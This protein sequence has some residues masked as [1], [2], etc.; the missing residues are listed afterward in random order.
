MKWKQKIAIFALAVV[1]VQPKAEVA[2]IPGSEPLRQMFG[3]ASLVCRCSVLSVKILH[4][5]KIPGDLHGNTYN[6]MSALLKEDKVYKADHKGFQNITVIYDEYPFSSGVGL[7]GGEYDR[8]FFLKV[9]GSNYAFVEPRIVF[10]LP[11]APS[12]EGSGIEQLERDLIAGLETSDRS[13]LLNTLRLLQA[14]DKLS[15]NSLAVLK[16]LLPASD[17]EM[18]LAIHAVLI[19]TGDPEEVAKFAAFEEKNRSEAF[20]RHLSFTSSMRIISIASALNQVRNVEALPSLIQLAESPITSIRLCALEA[21]R[22]IK[23]KKSIPTLIKHLDDPDSMCRYVA[24]ISLSETLN[25]NYPPYIGLFEKDESKYISVWK[26]WW[27]QEGRA[28]Y[29]PSPKNSLH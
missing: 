21:I 20:L 29:D 9:S 11:S 14:L 4:K 25:M 8:L 12:V 13:S 27:E 5:E 3:E 19:K 1:V 17:D 6:I 15:P 26:T 2:L 24:D 23:N 7:E 16:H 18:S 28:I 22:A 10:Q